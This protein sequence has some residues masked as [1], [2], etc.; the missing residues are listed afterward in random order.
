MVR[1]EQA[2]FHGRPSFHQLVGLKK[3]DDDS[4]QCTAAIA[5]LKRRRL[6]S[7]DAEIKQ[8]VI[9]AVPIDPCPEP[10]IT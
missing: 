10:P 5:L 6:V 8:I 7:S 3:S 1:A 2:G 4:K 9:S